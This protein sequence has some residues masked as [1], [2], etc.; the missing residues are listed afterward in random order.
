MSIGSLNYSRIVDFLVISKSSCVFVL[1]SLVAD[2]E[3]CT[4]TFFARPYPSSSQYIIPVHTNCAPSFPT[5]TDKKS[6]SF[7][8]HTSRDIMR[9]F[10]RRTVVIGPAFPSYLLLCVYTH[11]RRISFRLNGKCFRRKIYVFD[12]I[13]SF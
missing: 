13:R 2:L 6:T 7:G 9:S 5:G 3:I 12:E 8:S 11:S 4:Q 10:T 1:R